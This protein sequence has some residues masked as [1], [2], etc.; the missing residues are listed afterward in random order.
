LFAIQ[1]QRERKVAQ[2]FQ[3]ADLLITHLHHQAYFAH[4][5]RLLVQKQLAER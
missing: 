2:L 4:R 3:T 1:V 5:L